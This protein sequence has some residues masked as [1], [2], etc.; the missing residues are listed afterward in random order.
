MVQV[1]VGSIIASTT[2][3]FF[4]IGTIVQQCLFKTSSIL[5]DVVAAIPERESIRVAAIRSKYSTLHLSI[6][7]GTS[8][9]KKPTIGLSAVT[10]CSILSRLS[11]IQ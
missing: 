7:A 4:I 10:N 5:L 9:S 11:I 6:A 3:I 1:V 2:I 8:P